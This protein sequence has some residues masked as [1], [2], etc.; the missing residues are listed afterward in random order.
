MKKKSIKI[1]VGE[2]VKSKNTKGEATINKHDEGDEML[3]GMKTNWWRREG[4][5]CGEG[6]D[7]G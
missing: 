6:K 2:A 7:G 5:W 4:L 1:E 3:G